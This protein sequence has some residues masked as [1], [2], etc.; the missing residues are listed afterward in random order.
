MLGQGCVDL[1]RLAE[2]LRR[3]IPTYDSEEAALLE[4]E[5][6]IALRPGCRVKFL[7]PFTLASR[8]GVFMGDT[9]DKDGDLNYIV[10][11]LNTDT[12]ALQVVR[13]LPQM[14]LD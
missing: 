6:L 9:R 10:A 2:K 11:Y 1:E 13:V 14:I 4:A 7:E 3:K 5:R 8:N 12:D